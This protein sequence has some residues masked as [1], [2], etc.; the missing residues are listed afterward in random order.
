MNLSIEEILAHYDPSQFKNAHEIT[1]A[2]AYYSLVDLKYR[3]N[4]K[5]RVVLVDIRDIEDGCIA[6][7]VVRDKEDPLYGVFYSSLFIYSWKRQNGCYYHN[8]EKHLRGVTI[9]TNPDCE[10]ESYLKHKGIPYLVIPWVE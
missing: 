1:C 7:F 4:P 9:L 10:L 5:N 6:Q 8:Y 2:H 3:L